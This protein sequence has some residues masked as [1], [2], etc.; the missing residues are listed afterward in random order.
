MVELNRELNRNLAMNASIT[1]VCYKSK[2]LSN[3]EHPLMLR[4]SKDGKKK[5]IS[6]GLSIHPQL[7]DFSKNEP[8]PKCPNKDLINKIILDKKTEYQKE[9]L[10]LNS[11][12]KDYTAASL[13]ENKK[14]KYEPKTVIEFYKEL[15]QGFMNTS[16]TGN[17]SI[18]TN[19]LNS[20]KAFTHNKLN[21][22]FSD[23]DV[24]WLKR[25]EKWQRSNKNKET[26]ISL[27]FRTL[28]SAYNKAIEAKAT[29]DKFYPFKEFNINKFNTKTRKRAISKE[30]IMLIITTETINATFM[31]QL[32]RD[33]F[34]FSYLC[35]GIPFVDIANLTME[36]IIDGKLSY[37]RQKTHG[38]INVT[39]CEQAMEIIEKYAYHRKEAKYLFP[40]FD[41]RVHK[42]AQQK[43]NRVH[44]VCAQVN[45]ELRQ[46]AD[47]LE[48]NADLTTYVARH[49]FA[50]ILKRSGVN[51]GLISELMGHADITTTKIY[52]DSFDEEQVEQAMSN[53]L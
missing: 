49:S 32:A 25:Y 14:T 44:K 4:I 47:E 34:K 24:D 28:R 48:I 40:I 5:Y 7:W 17:K 46:L 39:I 19:S 18:Y 38:D 1:V 53:L 50:T 52:L 30:D 36:N 3:G 37:I 41:A 22:L 51:I 16:R 13:V 26:T 42:T 29:S 10:E 11:E 33:V 27:Q 35:A 2:T 9:I 23:I 43:A 8:K 20:L 12:Q 45:R 21:I 31:C 6:I 15:I